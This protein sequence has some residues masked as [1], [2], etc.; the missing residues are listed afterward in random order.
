MVLLKDT[1]AT[2]IA[3]HLYER[4]ICRYGA[5]DH[6]LSGGG[7]NI[8]TKVVTEECRVFQITRLHTSSYHPQTNATCECTNATIAQSIRALCDQHSSKWSSLLPGILAALRTVPSTEST[9]FSPFFILFKQECRMPIDTALRVGDIHSAAQPCMEEIVQNAELAKTLV[10]ENVQTAQDRYNKHHDGKVQP[11]QYVVGHANPLEGDTDPVQTN[12]KAIS[13][14]TADLPTD[15]SAQAPAKPTSQPS[16]AEIH[17]PPVDVDVYLVDRLVACKM[18]NKVKYYKVKWT[19]YKETTWEPAG[20]IAK[21]LT[22]LSTIK[23]NGPVTRKQP[24]NQQVI[25]LTSSF[26]TFTCE[27]HVVGV[28]VTGEPL[29]V[30]YCASSHPVVYIV[31]YSATVRRKTGV[32]HDLVGWTCVMTIHFRYKMLT[33]TT[34]DAGDYEGPGKH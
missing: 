4:I 33:I 25:F 15:P 1:T 20:N 8:L 28:F 24:G 18:V 22:K 16:D 11:P 26:V 34:R 19:G 17:V 13:N 23:S 9:L 2:T 21:R 27:K 14:T 5:P 31:G 7:Q 30:F 32:W 6:L 3:W 12:L 10:T 29:C